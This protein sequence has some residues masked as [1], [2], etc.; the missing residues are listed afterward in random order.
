ML[1]YLKKWARTNCNRLARPG[2]GIKPLHFVTRTAPKVQ[3]FHVSAG[4]YYDDPVLLSEPDR[5]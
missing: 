3:F 5:Y 2:P 1:F 4:T